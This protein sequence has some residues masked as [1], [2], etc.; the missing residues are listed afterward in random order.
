[1]YVFKDQLASITK[2]DFVPYSERRRMEQEVL[3]KLEAENVGAS[4]GVYLRVKRAARKRCCLHV[5]R[6]PWESISGSNVGGGRHGGCGALAM[7]L[8]VGGRYGAGARGHGFRFEARGNMLAAEQGTATFRRSFLKRALAGGECGLRCCV[9]LTV[10]GGALLLLTA[11]SLA[12]TP[13][14]SWCLRMPHLYSHAVCAPWAGGARGAAGGSGGGSGCQR[15]GGR[16]GGG[17]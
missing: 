16:I 5:K 6:V 12:R 15:R 4:V 10:C 2:K 7:V 8:L 3:A 9:R 14:F 1:M 17:C 11:I 13:P